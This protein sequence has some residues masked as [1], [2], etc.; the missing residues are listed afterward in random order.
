MKVH[1]SK[2]KSITN[3]FPSEKFLL[4]VTYYTKSIQNIY[5][6]TWSNVLSGTF[7][8][9][10]TSLKRFM[11]VK[12]FVE[13]T[14]RVIIVKCWNWSELWVSTAS[15]KLLTVSEKMD[16]FSMSNTYLVLASLGTY[17]IFSDSKISLRHWTT[18]QRKRKK[19]STT[20]L[21]IKHI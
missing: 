20:L 15:G 5:C 11:A 8:D 19:C 13:S 6:S 16:Q 10:N 1:R 14:G 12:T 2:L 7:P 18:S 3:R 9:F 21:P 4:W 17:L